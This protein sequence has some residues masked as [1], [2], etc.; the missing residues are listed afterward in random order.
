MGKS[1]QADV[2][3]GQRIRQRRLEMHVS[4][5]ELGECINVS[6]QQI[7]KYETG[8]NRVGSA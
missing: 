5:T 6:Y 8:V 2:L 7:Q 4:Q 1:S 3:I